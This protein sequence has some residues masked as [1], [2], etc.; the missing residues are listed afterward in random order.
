[1]ID[2]NETIGATILVV[3]SNKEIGKI[4]EF[5]INFETGKLLGF[6]L[7]EGLLKEQRI[8]RIEDVKEIRDGNVF[9][10][11]EM[12]VKPLNNFGLFE[13]LLKKEIKIKDNNVVTESGEELGKVV[14]FEMDDIS[15]RLEKMYV[16]TGFLRKLFKGQL[17]ISFDK[18]VSISKK[19]IVVKDDLVREE[20]RKPVSAKLE[21]KEMI[22]DVVMKDTE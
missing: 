7:S 2:Y 13:E 10:D 16:K 12:S 17:I 8:L 1:M 4:N 6:Q 22:S 9:V 18:I 5:I 3:S 11:S 15:Y 14:D 21:Q 20:Q 19:A